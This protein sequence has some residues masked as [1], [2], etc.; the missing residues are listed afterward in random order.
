MKH[1]DD[2]NSDAVSNL[3]GAINI[4]HQQGQDEFPRIG[5]VWVWF[6]GKLL[7][8]AKIRK[9]HANNFNAFRTFNRKLD[10]VKLETSG[11]LVWE[12]SQIEDIN[13]DILSFSENSFNHLRLLSEK[14]HVFHLYPGFSFSALNALKND[15]DAIVLVAYGSGNG[16]AELKEFIIYHMQVLPV[17][18]CTECIEGVTTTDYAVSL[19]VSCKSPRRTR[20]NPLSDIR[21][22]HVLRHDTRSSTHSRCLADSMVSVSNSFTRVQE[23]K[24]RG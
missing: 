18:V 13:E 19:A 10:P 20:S 22:S 9:V 17:L 15:S 12:D 21:H 14:V 1:W 24:R 2:P 16:P 6:N 7:H 8:P 3:I 4:I 11:T 23:S 5:M